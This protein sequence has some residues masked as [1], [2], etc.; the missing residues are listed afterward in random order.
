MVFVNDGEA[1]GVRQLAA[2][3]ESYAKAIL[4]P[5]KRQIRGPLPSQAAAL[6][7]APRAHQKHVRHEV[8]ASHQRNF[9]KRTP[10]IAP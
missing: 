10:G 6:Q 3:L 2:A 4:M 1:L 5:L 8:N 7:G 9:S